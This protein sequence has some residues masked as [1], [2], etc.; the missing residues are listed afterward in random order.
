MERFTRIFS[1]AYGSQ[2]GP[3]D[4]EPSSHDLTELNLL[5][6]ATTGV[7]KRSL[8]AGLAANIGAVIGLSQ[9]PA[10]LPVDASPNVSTTAVTLVEPWFPKPRP[11]VG[12]AP[13]APVTRRAATARP[14]VPAPSIATLERPKTPGDPEAKDQSNLEAAAP[15][16]ATPDVAPVETTISLPP[17]LRANRFG[18]ADARVYG[19]KPGDGG[20]GGGPLFKTENQRTASPTPPPTGETTLPDV[21]TRPRILPFKTPPYPAGAK[22][23]G[24][25]GDVVAAVRFEKLG[26]VAFLGFVKTLS[27][28]EL[29]AV[30]R[31]TV[32]K[33]ECV[34]AKRNNV[35]VDEEGTITVTFRLSHSTLVASF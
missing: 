15:P 26:R 22:K 13:A 11:A 3:G 21:F 25:Q 18:A 29:N 6:P 12:K 17:G 34:P 1:D 20:A 23:R 5:L 4:A 27:D 19:G 30:A 32:E 10:G 28:E 24:V 35:P 31:E 7:R 9:I 16:L 2:L 8:A 33:L 14:S